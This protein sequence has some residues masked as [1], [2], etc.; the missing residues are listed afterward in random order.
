MPL[1]GQLAVSDSRD[2]RQ[3]WGFLLQGRQESLD[4]V[5]LALCRNDHP[6]AVVRHAATQAETG[7]QRVNE[8]AKS[9]PLDDALNANLEPNDHRKS[10]WHTAALGASSWL[11]LIWRALFSFHTR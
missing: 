4:I 11:A 6:L 7:S 5:P 2:H 1:R 10:H 3:R 9:H 8:R